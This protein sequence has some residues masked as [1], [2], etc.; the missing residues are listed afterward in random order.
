[1]CSSVCVVRL[2]SPFPFFL[3]FKIRVFLTWGFFAGCVRGVLL[4]HAFVF[5]DAFAI[6]LCP[7][8]VI[9]PHGVSVILTGRDNFLTLR[10]LPLS[11]AFCEYERSWFLLFWSRLRLVLLWPPGSRIPR[12]SDSGASLQGLLY[13]WLVHAPPL[14][15]DRYLTAVW[16]SVLFILTG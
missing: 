13:S 2:W 4:F 1:M 6:A 10:V 8:L 14:D 9:V 3:I 7:C 5:S 12:F 16:F 15:S 11:S